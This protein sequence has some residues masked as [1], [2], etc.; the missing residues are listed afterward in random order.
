MSTNSNNNKI[1]FNIIDLVHTSKKDEKKVSFD[2]ENIF[3]IPNNDIVIGKFFIHMR[4][5][6]YKVRPVWLFIVLLFL[7]G[8]FLHTVFNGPAL[9]KYCIIRGVL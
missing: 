6:V 4:T 7:F 8:M 5:G 9:K 2:A 1:T 3:V